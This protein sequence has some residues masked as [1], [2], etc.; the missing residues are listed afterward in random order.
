MPKFPP[1]PKGAEIS[2]LAK[3]TQDAIFDAATEAVGVAR[4]NESLA[5]LI[6][7]NL[8]ALNMLGHVYDQEVTFEE[9]VTLNPP[10]TLSER[11]VA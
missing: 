4:L 9:D 2:D 1:I 8:R 5:I 3:E 7:A 11:D 10:I 6:I